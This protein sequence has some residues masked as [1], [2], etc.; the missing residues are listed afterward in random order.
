[1]HKI[2]EQSR[3][4]WNRLKC[5]MFR[6]QRSLSKNQYSI[7][8]INIITHDL[9]PVTWLNTPAP[10]M[11]S[12]LLYIWP[13]HLFIQYCNW[14]RPLRLKCLT[15]QSVCYVIAQQLPRPYLCHKNEPLPNYAQMLA[16]ILSPFH[17]T[18]SSIIMYMAPPLSL[19]QIWQTADIQVDISGCWFSSVQ[20]SWLLNPMLF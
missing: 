5:K 2:V 10:L 14:R 12:W 7:F 20:C 8:L 4:S 18:S 9:S 15:F 13:N 17:S 16:Y 6:P 11:T 3:I 1:M 19:F